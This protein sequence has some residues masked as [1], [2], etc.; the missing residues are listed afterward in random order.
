MSKRIKLLIYELELLFNIY[1]YNVIS[2]VYLELIIDLIKNL[3]YRRRLLISTIVID[4]EKKFEIEK[5][6]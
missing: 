5:L 4:G 6:L 1:I 3:Y 2:I